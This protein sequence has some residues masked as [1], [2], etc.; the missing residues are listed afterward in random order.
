VLRQAC[1][2]LC[3]EHAVGSTGS[4]LARAA[5]AM[6]DWPADQLRY[7]IGDSACSD[8]GGMLRTEPPA[9]GPR[10]GRG[11]RKLSVMACTVTSSSGWLGLRAMAMGGPEE[12]RDS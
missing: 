9:A 2:F 4:G 1:A 7:P 3:E 12:L 5:T 11:L 8:S 10:A 6:A